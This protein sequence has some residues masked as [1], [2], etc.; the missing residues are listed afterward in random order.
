M[1]ND[2]GVGS[3][4]DDDVR[5]VLS[6]VAMKDDKH[7]RDI[8]GSAVEIVLR[9]RRR[10]RAYGAAASGVAVAMGAS[11]VVWVSGGSAATRPEPGNSSPAVSTPTQAPAAQSLWDKEHD[12][13]N[14]LPGLVNPLLP[15]GLSLTQSASGGPVPNGGFWLR[16]PSGANDFT[17]SAVAKSKRNQAME[18]GCVAGGVCSHHQ[19]PG[20]TLYISTKN[21]TADYGG[22]SGYA[23]GTGKQVLSFSDE[24]EFVP[25]A[26]DGMVIDLMTSAEVSKEHY[27]AHPPSDDWQGQWPPPDYYTGPADASGVLLSPDEFATLI[28]K[29][30]FGAVTTVLDQYSPVSAA[31]LAQHKAADTTIEAAVKPVLPAGLTLSIATDDQLQPGDDLTLTGPS[32]ANMFSWKTDSLPK[33]WRHGQA[34]LSHTEPNCTWKEVPGGEIEITHS[35]LPG[36]AAAETELLAP[37]QAGTHTS[38]SDVYKYL[39]EDPNGTVII[40]ST[41]EQYR[42]IPWAAT[43]PTTGVY[44]DPSRPWPPPAHSGVP[45]NSGGPLLTVDQ[46]AALIQKPGITDIVQTVNTA[47]DKTGGVNISIWG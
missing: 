37:G 39:P 25:S 27:A 7:H 4:D 18:T 44:A 23:P 2:S 1:M 9:R 11:A 26:E 45:F 38:G 35:W 36:D 41:G 43:R 47:L 20:G 16:G 28:A 24:Y 6:Q 3:M 12:I 21:F 19:V 10:L 22:N 29:P 31:T 32:G 13:F 33:N 34:C 42:D 40:L 5:R 15:S 14:R 8:V 46:F 17:L 30:G